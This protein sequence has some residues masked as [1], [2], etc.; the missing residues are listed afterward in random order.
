[1]KSHVRTIEPDF[2]QPSPYTHDIHGGRAESLPH[3]Q[4]KFLT[5]FGFKCY[6]SAYGGLFGYV[7]FPESFEAYFDGTIEELERLITRSRSVYLLFQNR[8]WKIFF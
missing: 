1:M 7:Y 5:V 8:R 3:G 6:Q 2:C 4:K